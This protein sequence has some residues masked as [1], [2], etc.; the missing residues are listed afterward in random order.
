M[1]RQLSMDAALLINQ[2]ERIDAVSVVAC[3]RDHSSFEGAASAQERVVDRNMIERNKR[4]LTG[5]GNA[6]EHVSVP[7]HTQFQNQTYGLPR[8]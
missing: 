2:R 8:Q 6:T 3:F 5:K 1:E 4:G 7:P